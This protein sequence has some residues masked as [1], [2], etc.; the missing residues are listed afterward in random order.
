MATYKGIQGYSVQKLSS[1]PT[2]SEA[3]GQLWYNSSSGKFKIS[4]AGAG[5]WASANNIPANR[6]KAGG[7][8]TQTA[9][10]FVGGSEPT[11]TLNNALEFDGTDW[12]IGGTMNTPSI[13]ST[14]TAGTQTACVAGG[15]YSE[16]PAG[17][18]SVTDLYNGTAWT[19]GNDM[20]DT[21]RDGGACAGLQTAAIAMAGNQPGTKDMVE[22]WDGTSWSAGTD[23]NSDHARAFAAQAGTSTSTLCIGG[24]VSP[25]I[26]EEWN[27]S[28]WTE[29]N[30]INTARQFGGGTGTVTA[31]LIAGG[32]SP[33]SPYPKKTETE[34][35]DG[36]SWTEVGDIAT[37]KAFINGCGTQ[38]AAVLPGG[39]TGPSSSSNSVTAEVWN[40]P[41]YTNKTVTVS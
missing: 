20:T 25:G 8:G 21:G 36:T 6:S 18:P 39:V 2:A 35:Y 29:V 13:Y 1:D 14:Y 3:E 30:D 12:T 41:V 27:G 37:A 17:Y 24:A 19:T 16:S 31:A 32:Y 23:M 9:G 34:K 7:C 26:V 28:T 40:D 33:S 4:T 22:D 15:G 10:L 38:A 5:A 11:P